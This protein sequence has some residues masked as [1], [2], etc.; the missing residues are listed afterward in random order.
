[1]ETSTMPTAAQRTPSYRLHKPSGQAVVT[2]GGRDVYL[3][4]HGSPESRAEYDRLTAEWLLQG[5]PQ[6]ARPVGAGQDTTVNEMVL[7]Y[8]RHADAYYVK[9]GKPTSE[10]KNVRL[11]LRPLRRLYGDTLARDFGPLALKT[12]RQAMVDSGL[13]RNEVNKRSRQVVRAFKW[14][15]GEEMVPA[16]AHHGL[17]AVS[18]LRSGRADV[19]E[20]KPVKPVPDAFVDAIRPYV[21]RQVWGM[22][23]L[24]RLSGMKP[25]EVCAMRTCDVDTRGKVWAYT[26]G[27]HKTAHHGKARVVHLGPRAQA[28]L[29]EWL[30]PEL[31]APLFQPREAEAERQAEKRRRRKSKV[32]P[33]QV[34]RK[35]ARPCKAPG[36]RY[37][38]KGIGR[39]SSAVPA[40]LACR[41][42]TRTNCATTR[43]R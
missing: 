14:A 37:T 31:T 15:V 40:R 20:S 27:R 36:D 29:R 42:G 43:P 8:L 21:S 3:G 35:K 22:V 30:R 17:L 33:S 11:A 1:M 32:P 13:C 18:G 39:R 5:R 2:L 16:T 38:L 26:P 28:V 34:S 23:E 19:R 7:A 25:G 6:V 12:V 9:D 4:R 10:P 24:Q 41:P